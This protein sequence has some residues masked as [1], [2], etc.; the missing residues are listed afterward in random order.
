MK[1]YLNRDEKNMIIHLLVFWDYLENNV[2]PTFKNDLFSSEHQWNIKVAT[3]WIK[4]TIFGILD[5]LEQQTI[6]SILRTTDTNSVEILP[7]KELTS[8]INKILNDKYAI[9]TL[10]EAA[11]YKCMYNCCGS[12]K[13]CDLYPILT[14]YSIPSFDTEDPTVCPYK[15]PL[16]LFQKE[17]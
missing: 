5:N 1:T 6:K 16:S 4:K 11:L 10:S 17:E 8:K 13:D 7:K 15:V 2:K 3:T 12:N 14:S 9:E